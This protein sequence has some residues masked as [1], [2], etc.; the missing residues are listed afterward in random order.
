MEIKS[1]AKLTFFEAAS[2]IIGHGVGAG[3]LSVPYIASRN[4]IGDLLWILAAVYLINLLLHFMIAEL[5]LHNGGAQ[6][7]K[8]FE[9]DLFIGKH[10]KVLTWGAFVILGLSV[11]VNVSGFITG[12][13][14]VLVS[15]LGMP[16]WAAM[17]VFY[18][19]AAAVVFF[20]MKLV[21]ICEKIAV[22]S[23]AAVIGILVAA[24]LK[25]G[26]A[27]FEGSRVAWTNVMAL[28][29]MVSFSLSAVMSV[30]QVVKGLDGDRKQ[31]AGAIA[32]G[33][34]LNLALV[35]VI[36]F[37][38]LYTVGSGVTENGALVDLSAKLGGWVSI[39]GYVFSLLA[40][41]TSFWANTLNLRDVF[42]EQTGMGNRKSWLITS[43]PCLFIALLG[44]TSFVGFSRLAG[45]V[46]VLTGVGVIAAYHH[47]R[48][49]TGSS[50]ICG[51]LG[52]LPFQILVVAG[53]LA[54]TAGALFKIL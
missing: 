48:K 5:S 26:S 51:R 50:P 22:L 21:G 38:T 35:G 34:G 11:I 14:A 31:I 23:M 44:L 17:T 39:I 36:T 41:A 30:P 27:D 25:N 8:C 7:I 15:W 13:G 54:A 43:L 32:A 16:A 19:A 4:S 20:G 10:G 37:I 24:G 33:T 1:E 18:G 3:I 52:G 49:R 2:L 12:G 28:Y 46:Q 45:L 53:S 47:A 6:F 40:L 9:N 42:A 29:S